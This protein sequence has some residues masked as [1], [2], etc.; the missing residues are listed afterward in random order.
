MKPAHERIQAIR[1]KQD[2]S[3]E[4]LAKRLGESRLW[5]WRIETGETKLLVEDLKRFAKALDVDVAELVA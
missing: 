1:E 5:I 4:E 2:L 3:R